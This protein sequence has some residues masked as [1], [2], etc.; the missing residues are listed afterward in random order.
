[1]LAAAT[2]VTA[3]AVTT[4]PDTYSFFSDTDVSGVPTDSDNRPVELGLRFTSEKD[5][6]LSAVRF[7]KARG[8]RGPHTV[9]VWSAT[10]QK[11]A[12]GAT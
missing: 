5:G 2:V 3:Y 7:L 9:S 11:L 8:D 10:G 12:T 1:M 6:T 4:E